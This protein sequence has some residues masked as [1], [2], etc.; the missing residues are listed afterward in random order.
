MT[1]AKGH[2]VRARGSLN[3]IHALLT[4]QTAVIVL[5]SVN[6]LAGLTRG[7]VSSNE[8]LRWMDLHNM[9]TLPLLGLIA[10]GLLKRQ[11]EDAPGDRA[12]GRRLHVLL[13]LSFTIGVYLLGAGYGS[14]EV[15]N[16][17]HWRFCRGNAQGA[18]CQIIIYND[19]VF[20]HLV[21]FAGYVLVNGS[22]LLIQAAF[23]HPASLTL[24]DLTALSLN[25]LFV[26]AGVF[27]NLAFEEISMDLYVV[28]LLAAL[29][30]FLLYRC[31]RQPLL[32]YSAVGHGVGLVATLAYKIVAGH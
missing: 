21:F 24:A 9:L 22:L 30:V 4:V 27:A 14:H 29:S 20:A 12:H 25:G 28:A 13:E 8:F 5:V 15:T 10:L 32:I 11:I 16:Y 19:D 26:G 23:P 6:R 31:G 7:Y 1:G 17:L 3:N 2:E 18:L